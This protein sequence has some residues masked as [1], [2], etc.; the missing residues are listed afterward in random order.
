MAAG[1]PSAAATDTLPWG[2][3]NP[4]WAA[5]E[6][7]PYNHGY[8]GLDLLHW[9]PEAD[10]YSQYL[11]SRVPL[12]ERIDANAATQRD[13]D[14]PADTQMLNLAGDYGNAFFES[15]HDNNVFSQ[16]LFNYWQYTDFYA[17]WHGQPT[18]DVRQGPVRHRPERSGQRLAAALVR[19]RHDEPAEPCLYERRPPQRRPRAGYDL[20]LRQRPRRAD[21]P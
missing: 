12:Q 15:F 17:T 5:G 10:V 13:S 18:Q 4:D 2:R 6:N 1:V 11:R 16:Y 19:V 9:S 14:L 3:F 21:L 20:L 7:Q 8:T